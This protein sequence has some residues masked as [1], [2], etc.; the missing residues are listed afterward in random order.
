MP[1][2]QTGTKNTNGLTPG[3]PLGCNV[4]AKPRPN[5]LTPGYPLGCNVM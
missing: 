5:G 2:S 4:M 1:T 3:Y